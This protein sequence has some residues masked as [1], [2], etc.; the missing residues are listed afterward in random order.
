MFSFILLGIVYHITI[1]KSHIFS[2]GLPI[3]S[4]PRQEASLDTLVVSSNLLRAVHT[5]LLLEASKS[6]ASK[7][8][9]SA[10]ESLEFLWIKNG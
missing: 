8:D 9:G 4:Y 3:L 10:G 5:A 2:Q 6:K 7:V 1:Q